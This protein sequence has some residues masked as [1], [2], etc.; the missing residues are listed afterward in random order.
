M[1]H[2]MSLEHFWSVFLPKLEEYWETAKGRKESTHSFP[3]RPDEVG[4]W[5]G[6]GGRLRGGVIWKE[7]CVAC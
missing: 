3:Y 7:M 2:A 5:V 4:V 1:W 6:W